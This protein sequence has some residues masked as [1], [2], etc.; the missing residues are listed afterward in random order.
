MSSEL[1]RKDFNA[2]DI[3]RYHSG[4]MPDMERHAL[5]KA[6][7][8]DPFLADAIDGYQHT[9]TPV[10]DIQELQLRLKKKT[11]SNKR[12]TG[13]FLS[14]PMMRMAALFLIVI[15]TGYLI[16]RFSVIT[17]DT[18]A[19]Q[20]DQLE[21]ADNKVHDATSATTNDPV[22]AGV[23]QDSISLQMPLSVKVEPND[24]EKI[25]SQKREQQQTGIRPGIRQS[26]DALPENESST[27]SKDIKTEEDNTTIIAK[28]AIANA[29]ETPLAITY[30]GKVTNMSG[31]PVPNVS[32][33]IPGT[34]VGVLTDLN[35]RFQLKAADTSTKAIVSAVGFEAK[36]L[37]L[38]NPTVEKN[39]VLEESSATLNEV[40]VTGYGT[41]KSRNVSA[42][43]SK[44]K[45]EELEPVDGWLVYNDYIS[46][47]LK[48]PNNLN[49]KP[50]GEVLLS[51]D[52][53]KK[54]MPT[55]IQIEK[56]LCEP[57]D[58]EAIRLLKGGPSWKRQKGKKGKLKIHF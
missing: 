23:E 54:G 22:G 20:K 38:T 36:P 4:Q 31:Q 49:N 58:Q 13:M 55:N 24:Q 1:H 2:G 42:S 33:T 50:K 45:A 7:L 5:E 29:K 15:G 44:I 14:M 19:I 27:R 25:L 11:G 6:A 34:S 21:K 56:S 40:V 30:N 8:E 46:A 28:K 48:I 53:T 37:A 57:C 41:R 43:Q 17:P 10:T 39:I 52:V 51:F 32:V 16:Y 12:R 47:N 26:A 35:G 9:K 18:I 3:Q